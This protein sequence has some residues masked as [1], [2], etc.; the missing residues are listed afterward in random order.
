MHLEDVAARRL[1]EE[2][3]VISEDD[4]SNHHLPDRENKAAKIN[5]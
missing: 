3:V 2:L 1:K 5:Q 4:G